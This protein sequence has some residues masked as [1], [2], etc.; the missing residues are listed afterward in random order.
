MTNGNSSFNT[1][2]GNP[3][4]D[5]RLQ[6]Q[7]GNWVALSELTAKNALILVFYPGDFSMVCTKQ[8]CAYQ[9]KYEEF[10]NFG[11]QIA[12]IS[13]NDI[14]SHQDFRNK[15][16]FAFPLLSDPKKTIFKAFGVVSLFMLGGTSRAVFILSAQGPRKTQNQILYRYIEPTTLTH[17]RPDELLY[18][19]Q[20][21]KKT[22][23]F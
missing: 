23:V 8:L 17:R 4:P 22:G 1:L 6:D 21:L 20:N 18:I 16:Q 14:K 2:P 19:I 11:F 9:D 3:A 12:G 15:Y 7:E 13:P 10:K 5:F